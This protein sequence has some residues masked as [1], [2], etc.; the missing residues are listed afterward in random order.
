MLY[1]TA[2]GVMRSEASPAQSGRSPS[3]KLDLKVVEGRL[4]GKAA[5]E[6]DGEKR[7]GAIDVGRAKK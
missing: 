1:A 2:S 4:K 5:A 6:A 7:E 3:R